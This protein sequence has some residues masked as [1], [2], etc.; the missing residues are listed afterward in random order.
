MFPALP[1]RDAGAA[2]TEVLA[3]ALAAREDFAEND[4]I[5]AGYTYLGQF[6]DHD[7]TF[8]PVSLLQRDND[9][10]ALADFRT[11]R[12]D[13]DSV[14]G[15]GPADQPYLYDWDGP[16]QLRGVKL[17]L[18]ASPGLNGKGTIP[19]LP[20]NAQE[21]AVIGDGRNDEHVIIAQLHLLFLRF[22]NRIVDDL[23]DG[24]SGLD[25]MDLLE[26]AR[27]RVRWHYQ[28]IVAHEYLP[29]IADTAAA[30]TP[31]RHFT[32]REEP[33]MPVEFSG[34]AFRFGHSMVRLSYRTRD[35]GETVHIV[36]TG[37]RP[38]GQLGGFRRV[39][40]ELEVQWHH[41]FA[42]P[43]HE[44]PQKSMRINEVLSTPLRALPPDGAAL[45]RLNLQRGRA[46][47]LPAGADVARAMGT[48]PLTADELW[49][50]THIG[51]TAARRALSDATP[52]W[53]Y[54]LREASI[55]AGGKR[56][57]PVGAGI[58]SEVLNGLLDGDPQSFRRQWPR[59]RPE[60]AGA[61]GEFRMADLVAFTNA[62][63]K[64]RSS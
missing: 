28:W 8:D 48:E 4:H 16:K 42:L 9:P 25:G 13:L 38:G 43:D 61:N 57:G 34:A 59:W 21:R 56:L 29:L 60:Y 44:A 37:G 40:A 41:F 26:E 24:G 47:G 23:R 32:W 15:S 3:A 14:Y 5:P 17:L 11:P 7:I 58:V 55:K 2:A 19:D 64:R 35:G 46:L 51:D 53:F 30:D 52:L 63:A 27:R 45:A 31:R 18:G 50:R 62:P 36:G 22:H 33:F 10:S 39:P 6:I 12:F 54:L 49:A 20:R 1:R